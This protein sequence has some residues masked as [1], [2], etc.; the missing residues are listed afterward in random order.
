MRDPD[1]LS[2]RE[3]SGWTG[4]WQVF[5]PSAAFLY[6]V[7]G[8]SLDWLRDLAVEQRADGRV[9]N[10]APDPLLPRAPGVARTTSSRA[11]PAGATP[12][13]WSRG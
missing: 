8:F 10:Y 6:D 2:Q 13:S 9:R 5:L 3:R 12:S 1:R 7:A 11:R 4:D